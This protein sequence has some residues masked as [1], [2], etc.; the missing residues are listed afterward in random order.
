MPQYNITPTAFVPREQKK[1]AE[2]TGSLDVTDSFKPWVVL[3]L[4]FGDGRVA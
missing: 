1:P 2:V 4:A 3:L